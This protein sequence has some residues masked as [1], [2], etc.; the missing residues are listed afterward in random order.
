MD[1][2]FTENY[3]KKIENESNH[4]LVKSE[5]RIGQILDEISTMTKSSS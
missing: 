4:K 2:S 5:S 3:Q 1:H